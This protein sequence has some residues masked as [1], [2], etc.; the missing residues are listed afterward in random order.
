MKR[1]LTDGNYPI[2]LVFPHIVHG[3]LPI[4]R[5]CGDMR[6]KNKADMNTNGSGLE[7]RPPRIPL[8][9]ARLGAPRKQL[10]KFMIYVPH[11]RAADHRTAMMLPQ[12]CSITEAESNSQPFSSGCM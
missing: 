5:A 8:P 3:T 12:L 6:N 9:I 11:I 1:H 2:I 4:D 10:C 7:G